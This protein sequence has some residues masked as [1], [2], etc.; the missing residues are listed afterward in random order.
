MQNVFE[1]MA[2]KPFAELRRTRFKEFPADLKVD[3][4]YVE[5][6]AVQ[7]GTNVD[8]WDILKVLTGI[9]TGNR[10][11]INKAFFAH[12]ETNKTEKQV[13]PDETVKALETTSKEVD[14]MRVAR[15][16]ELSSV[17]GQASASA[18]L[19][20]DNY[21][22]YV[23]RAWDAEK[24]KAALENRPANYIAEEVKS[25]LSEGFW[26][27]LEYK[28][29]KLRLATTS[30]IVMV[31]K[32]L[33]AGIDRRVNLGR[34]I[35]ELSV[36]DMRLKV[37]RY[38]QNIINRQRYF[39]PYISLDNDI[40]WGNAADTARSLLT[41]G[42]VKAIYSLLASLLTT[43]GSGTPWS[44]LAEFE[45]AKDSP[46]VDATRIGTTTREWCDDCNEERGA[47]GCGDW[48]GECDR[49]YDD[50]ECF[51]CDQCDHRGEERCERHYCEICETDERNNCGCCRECENTEGNCECCSIC[52]GNCNDCGCCTE[53]EALQDD[54]TR[55]R[56]CDRHDGH[57]PGCDS[58]PTEAVTDIF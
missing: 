25:L 14:R 6:L 30:D 18:K 21:A 46:R 1:A 55:C 3:L 40:C 17:Q 50:C 4:E 35:A 52:G 28:E 42:Q 23:K 31:E 36:R 11:A 16:S 7:T 2:G 10:R 56:E 12:A 49:H 34:L 44:A 33:A 51:A 39:H 19:A 43:Y 38:R 37:L 32:N 8:S 27:F 53:C 58:A 41:T 48:C 47:C 5:Q 22:T 57:S 9:A 24:E 45:I 20:Y 54:C 29:A 26:Q 15:L 13:L